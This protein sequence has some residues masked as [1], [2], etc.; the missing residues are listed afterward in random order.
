MSSNLMTN[1][2]YYEL[3]FKDCKLMMMIAFLS[4]KQHIVFCV[5]INDYILHNLF[6]VYVIVRNC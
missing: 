3:Q 6:V 1:R 2:Q 5:L 4:T